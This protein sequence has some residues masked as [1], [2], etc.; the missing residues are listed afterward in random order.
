ASSPILTALVTVQV[1][2]AA[3]AAYPD[4]TIRDT[5]S[6]LVVR[7]EVPVEEQ[8]GLLPFKVAELAG[9][10]IAGVIPGRAL[11]LSDAA[12]DVPGANVD[13]HMFVAIAPGGPAQA[14]ER[15]HFARDVFGSVP[16]LKDI[17]IT[18]SEPLRIAGQQGHQIIANG[19]DAVGGIPLT[20]VQ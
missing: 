20:V 1:P 9:F 4:A 7:A 6:S 17:R 12:P 13:A 10:R 19:K 15:D 11:M 2:E 16:N 8:L 3:T 14:T 5:L 18:A